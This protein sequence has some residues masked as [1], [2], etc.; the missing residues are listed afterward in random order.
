M[1]C[2]SKQVLIAGGGVGA[3]ETLMAL[4]DLA[5]DRV[6]VTMVA[7]ER[8]F[9]LK[10]LR[11][12]EAFGSGGQ[13][14]RS[15]SGVA[16]AFG[17][18]LLQDTL[19]AVRPESH[20]A[21]LESGDILPYDAL[22]LAV[23]ARP[24]PP[25]EHALTFGLEPG[26]DDL[27]GIV[28]DVEQGYAKS[29]AF[30][31]APGVTW[32]LPLYEIAMMTAADVWS[33]GIEDA[34]VMLV[35]PES[36][37]LAIFGASASEAVGELLGEA[38][39]AFHGSSYADVHE[40]G[41]IEIRPAARELRVDRVVTAP[42]LVGPRVLG[43]PSDEHGFIPV[44]DHGRVRG[45]RDVY[46]AGD[47]ADF[48]IKQ[49]GL[50]TQMADA[51]ATHIARA[52]GAEIDERPFRPVLRG[53]L[54]TGAGSEYLRRTL[55][56]GDGEGAASDMKLWWPPTKVSGRYLSAWLEHPEEPRVG[57]G[58]TVDVALPSKEEIKR[59]ALRLDPYSPVPA[60]RDALQ[61]R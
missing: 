39:V 5:E 57:E 11:T 45:Q 50:A 35:T 46:A 36:A 13:A 61:H 49:G 37:P 33:M 3:L 23:G 1:A 9:E 8:E 42:L 40:H 52:A 21:V 27:A 15:L 22:V 38:H 55:H 58:V 12:A 29:V 31:V 7:P 4:H 53:K 20:E 48:P 19:V 18:R 28:A 24:V 16:E 14:P 41:R 34:R 47:G 56:G 17:G 6:K 26:G 30:V 54:L 32:P 60:L 10:A 43:V 59:E 2:M 44:D 51:V 25:Y